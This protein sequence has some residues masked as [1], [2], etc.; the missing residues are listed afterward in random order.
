MLSHVVHLEVNL[1]TVHD[2]GGVGPVHVGRHPPVELGAGGVQL[3]HAL[4]QHVLQ[5]WKL[6]AN[7]ILVKAALN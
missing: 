6:G 2:V 4:L 7:E 1:F 5:A 3:G